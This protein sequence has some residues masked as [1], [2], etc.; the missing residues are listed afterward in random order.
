MVAAAGIPR[1]IL[2]DADL[3]DIVYG[4]FIANFRSIAEPIIGIGHADTGKSFKKLQ[5]LGE[6]V[7][8]RLV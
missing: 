2:L 7:S 5:V 3:V 4:V 6:R 8:P 1:H